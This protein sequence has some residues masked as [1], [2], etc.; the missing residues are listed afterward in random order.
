MNVG[1]EHTSNISNN[2]APVAIPAKHQTSTEMERDLQQ[3]M[4]GGHGAESKKID[5][6]KVIE[7]D[8]ITT[9]GSHKGNRSTR[10]HR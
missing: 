9:R 3:K 7:A 1:S 5:T 8:K 6:K 2:S 10:L 4:T